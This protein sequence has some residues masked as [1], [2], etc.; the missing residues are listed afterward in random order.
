MSNIKS[1]MSN[2]LSVSIL[3]PEEVPYPSSSQKRTQEGDIILFSTGANT[4]SV[5]V[6]MT[7]EGFDSFLSSST[8]DKAS[9]FSYI[10]NRYIPS[11][12]HG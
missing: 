4:P 2:T 10:F 6:S 9:V 3:P 12:A 8:A 7:K 5:S 11:P 1:F